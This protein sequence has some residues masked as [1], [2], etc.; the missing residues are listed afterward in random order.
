MKPGK[1]LLFCFIICCCVQAQQ[2]GFDFESLKRAQ[3]NKIK[4]VTCNKEEIITYDSVQLRI[5]KKELGKNGFAVFTAI[6]LFD[7]DGN[8]LQTET[9]NASGKE[10]CA[11]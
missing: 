7:A 6:R 2:Y 9:V 3:K 1:I 4:A 11:A 10:T 8:I 5:E